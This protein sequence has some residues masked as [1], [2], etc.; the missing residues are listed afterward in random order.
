MSGA[1]K[2]NWRTSACIS[3]SVRLSFRL[4]ILSK[5]SNNARPYRTQLSRFTKDRNSPESL[6]HR[7]YL[8]SILIASKKG[9]VLSCQQER[10]SEKSESKIREPKKDTWSLS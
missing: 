9:G 1:L 4:A 3:D 2:I 5:I 7:S 8:R 10:A 6:I